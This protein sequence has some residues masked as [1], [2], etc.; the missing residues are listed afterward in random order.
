MSLSL[1]RCLRVVPLGAVFA[2][3]ACPHHGGVARP[4]TPD[5]TRANAETVTVRDPE[6]ERRAAQLELRLLERDAQIEELQGRLDEARREVVRNMAKLQTLAS[7]A[8]AA[9]GM[10][11]T[12]L[13]LQSLRLPAGQAVAPEIVQARQLLAESTAEFDNQNYGGALYLANQAKNLSQIG[14]GR[15]VVDRSTLRNGEVLFALPIRLQ[16]VGRTNVREGPG[17]NFRVTYTVDGGAELTGDSYKDEWVRV[18]D[19][20][21]RSGWIFRTRITRKPQPAPTGP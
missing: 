11:E 1:R 12:E 10:A 6:L 9:S 4:P 13:A 2:L 16:V 14:R 15:L 21:S 17:A 19:D 5:S 7:R 20:P 8:E 3:A 18:S